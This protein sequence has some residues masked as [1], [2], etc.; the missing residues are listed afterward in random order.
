MIKTAEQQYKN[1]VI[2]ILENGGYVMD[3]TGTGALKRWAH[4]YTHR[5]AQSFPILWS[6]KVN[7]EKLAGEILWIMQDQSND[8]KLLKEKY[9]IGIWDEWANESG[10]IGKAYGYQV[11][12]HK[13][14]DRLIEGL[15]NDP[16]S[17]RHRINLMSEEDAP[18][19]ELE[20]CAFMTLWYVDPV[21][22]ELNMTLFQ[23]SGD[24]GLGVPFNMAQYALLQAMI[25]QVTG[26]KVGYFKH[27]INDAHIYVNH[28][29]PLKQQLN[30]GNFVGKG[31]DKKPAR[32]GRLWLNPEITD[33]YDFTL[34]DIKLLD[35]NHHPHI[36]MNVSV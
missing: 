32:E 6:K 15:K 31:F 19:M 8:T 36:K 25:A 12:K 14:I 11:R 7:F 27:Y 21:T 5:P 1:N 18:E 3:R 16:Y 13:Q 4:E 24:M 2:D 17:R 23:R 34:D 10:L 22:H 26:Y 30:R 35:Y 28:I 20:P 33:F 29:N 9:G